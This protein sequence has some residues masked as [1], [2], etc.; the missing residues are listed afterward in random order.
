LAGIE[1]L[2]EVP[3]LRASFRRPKLL[4]VRSAGTVFESN[5]A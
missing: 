1:V 3:R 4:N 2:A 5:P